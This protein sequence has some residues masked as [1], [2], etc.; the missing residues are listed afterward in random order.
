MSVGYTSKTE[1]L[2]EKQSLLEYTVIS[3]LDKQLCK[4]LLLKANERLLWKKKSW[5]E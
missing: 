4:N 1:E 5:L 2:K 3:L